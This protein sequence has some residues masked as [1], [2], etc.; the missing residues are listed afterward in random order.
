MKITNDAWKVQLRKGIF[1]LLILSLLDKKTMYGYEINLAINNIPEFDIPNG[2]IYP[3]LQ[4]LTKNEWVTFY[5]GESDNGPRRKYYQIT[6][7]G[8][9]VFRNRVDFYDSIYKILQQ[10]LN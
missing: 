8:R 3:I 10:E 9:E 4:R 7:E 1:E 2:S 6:E 5:W